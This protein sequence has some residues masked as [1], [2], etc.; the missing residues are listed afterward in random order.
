[1]L[2]ITPVKQQTGG[3]FYP[4]DIARPGSFGGEGRAQEQFA[5]S[6]QGAANTLAKA[7]NEKNQLENLHLTNQY[8]LVDALSFDMHLVG[9]KY[10]IH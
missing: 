7:W 10:L 2:K 8:Q 5:R 6:V 9:R 3:R 1:M 4:G